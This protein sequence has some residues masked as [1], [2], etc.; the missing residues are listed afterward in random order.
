MAIL[1]DFCLCCI[2]QV[3]F[4]L[5]PLVA[6]SENVEMP[7]VLLKTVVQVGMPLA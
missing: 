1:F 3:V 5:T 2:S 6:V 7:C 4:Q